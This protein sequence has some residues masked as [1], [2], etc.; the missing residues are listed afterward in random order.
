MIH[1]RFWVLRAPLRRLILRGILLFS[2]SRLQ[3][4][5]RTK[6]PPLDPVNATLS[7]VYTLLYYDIASKLVMSGFEPSISYLHEPFREHF[8]LASDIEECVR[9]DANSFVTKLFWKTY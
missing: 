1:R 8:A 2:Q 6:Q 9:A 7:F 5:Y 3:K 4:G